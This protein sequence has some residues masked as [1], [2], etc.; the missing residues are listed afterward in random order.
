MSVTSQVDLSRL[1]ALPRGGVGDTADRIR[2]LIR[3][4]ILRGDLPEGVRLNAD[5]L[6]RHL[7]VSHI[8]LREA[9]RALAADGWVLLR[10]HQGAFVR[11]RSQQELADLFELRAQVEPY[12]AELAA[13]RRSAE[14]LS[15]MEAV[16]TEQERT[17]DPIEFARLNAEFHSA[18]GEASQNALLAAHVRSLNARTRFYFSAVA[19]ARHA[20]SV[21]EHRT[22][23]AAIRRRADAQVRELVREH[24]LQTQDELDHVTR[25][26]R[27][28]E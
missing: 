25:E 5:H 26:S 4:S 23:V 10:P 17:A 11:S 22:I 28:P 15:I 14:Q 1:P 18:V 3:E 7:G 13:Q 21:E 9:I 16:V 19:T 12:S 20:R 27:P 2:E 8:P 6:G 24:V